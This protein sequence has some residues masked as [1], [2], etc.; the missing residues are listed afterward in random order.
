M[1]TDE[2]RA[3]AA[4]GDRVRGKIIKGIGGF[5][6]VHDGADTVYACRAKGIFRSR[7]VK[8]LVGDDVQLTV[9]DDAAGEACIDEILPR[10]SQRLR[11]AV[12][13]Q[14]QVMVVFALTH[15][16]PNLN[17][18]DRLL[19]MLALQQVPVALCFNKS[20]LGTEA[21]REAYRHT[22]EQAGYPVFFVS[23]EAGFGLEALRRRMKGKT[24]ALA[25]P[26][27]VG[28]SSLTNR[29]QPEAAMETGEISRKIERGKHTTRHSQLIF[30]EEGT[31]LMD[32]PGFSS[33]YPPELEAGELKT[34]FPE[35]APFEEGCRFLGCVHVGERVC[36]VKQAL[37]EGRL[38][39]SRYE[40]YLQMY[41]EL[42]NRRK[43]GK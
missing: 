2:I 25:G 4:E 41:E 32:T 7:G 20:D 13:N 22:Y 24:T 36:G 35:F 3:H 11:P 29:L 1:K 30:L 26:S 34:Y 12:A 5:Y 42:K 6:Y 21:E 31:Y 10:R 16:A 17:L 28:K 39:R 38:S 37:E 9:L 40:T 18:L 23:A 27:G 8:P 14:D 43:Y 19:V 15:P 33:L